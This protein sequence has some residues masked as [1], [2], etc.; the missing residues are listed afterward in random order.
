MRTIEEFASLHFGARA[1]IGPDG[2]VVGAI[3]AG[4]NF[5]GESS[6]LRSARSSV[7]SLTERLNSRSVRE[8]SVVEPFTTS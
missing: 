4:V 7:G 3:A 8:S 6:G 1:L 5:L 2:D